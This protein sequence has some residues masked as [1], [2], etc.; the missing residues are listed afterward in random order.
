MKPE[1]N[2][3]RK[4]VVWQDIRP[5][6]P[7]L[8]APSKKPKHKLSIANFH[9]ALTLVKIRNAITKTRQRKIIFM[10]II[11]IVISFLVLY[12]IHQKIKPT[13]SLNE[14]PSVAQVDGLV[15]GAPSYIPL[16]PSGKTLKDFGGGYVRSDKQPSFIYID[17]IDA[18]QINVSEQPL[19][20][21]FKQDPGGQIAT[22]A[23][24]FNAT[25][26]ISLG[27]TTI[28]IG[29]YG[30]GIQRILFIKNN[31][32]VLVTSSGSITVSQWATYVNSLKQS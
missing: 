2:S 12:V 1:G 10:L 18:T 20:D 27:S 29:S 11:F 6:R 8:N 14:A 3:G 22:L 28:Y 7:P 16:L 17:K 21:S 4:R 23:K 26:K 30:Q 15:P 32:L 13:T 9:I 19:P 5:A 31:L 24:S 25:E